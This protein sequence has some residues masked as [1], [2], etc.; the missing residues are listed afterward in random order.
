MSDYACECGHSKEEHGN[1]PKYPGSTACTEED[2]QCI[3]YE[4]C[5]DEPESER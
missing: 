4:S 2:C 3:A 1:D 5:E